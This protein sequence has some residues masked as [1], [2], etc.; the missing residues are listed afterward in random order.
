MLGIFALIGDAWN[1]GRRQP[2]LIHASFWLLL[3][4]ML[5]IMLLSRFV[6]LQRFSDPADTGSAT[7]AFL[8]MVILSV[9]FLW[10]ITCVLVIGKRLIAAKA[11][12]SRTSFKSVRREARGFIIPLILTSVLRS[13]FTFLWGILLIVPGIIYA[14]RTVFY[15]I[16][17]VEE[18]IAYRAA[19]K[20]SKDIVRGQLWTVFWKVVVIALLLFVPIKIITAV[21]LAFSSGPAAIVG[22]AIISTVLT[23]VSTVL[24]LLCLIEMYG[25]LRPATAPIMGSIGSSKK[26]RK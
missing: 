25:A 14:I 9:I 13:V 12:R 4:P 15:A 2:V 5:I 21:L 18:G 26:K 8:G 10:G 17:I 11:G 24:F 22:I 19:L 6:V 3:L 23:T 20:R 16:I 7:A 1:F